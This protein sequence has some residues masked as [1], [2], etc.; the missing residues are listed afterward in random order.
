MEERHIFFRCEDIKIEGL[1]A[2]FSD[3]KLHAGAVLCHPHPLMGG[4]MHN[5]LIGRVKTALNEAG[6]A[7]LRFNFRGAGHSGGKHGGGKA[8]V[9]DVHSALEFLSNQEGID[10]NRIYLV[11]YSFGATVALHAGMENPKVKKIVAIAPGAR[12]VDQALLTRRRV[13]ILIICADYDD[14]ASYEQWHTILQKL[15]GDWQ[16]KKIF[17]ANHFFAYQ[18]EEVGAEVVEFLK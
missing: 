14:F 6:I 11:G 3:S 4:S 17:G 16:L 15:T 5:A 13:P 1:L 10:A 12:Q 7:T 18:L 2:E 8:E 9:E